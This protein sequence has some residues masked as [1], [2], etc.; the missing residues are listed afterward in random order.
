MLT[1]ID[2]FNHK[3]LTQNAEV[4]ISPPWFMPYLPQGKPLKILDLAAG[5]S[6]L[7]LY[8][9]HQ[10]HSLVFVDGSQEAMQKLSAY[11]HNHGLTTTTWVTDLE[12]PKTKLLDQAWFKKQAYEVILIINY[13]N[14][15][16]THKVHQL[17]KPKGVLILETFYGQPHLQGPKN[18]AFYLQN[19][20]L[21]NLHQSYRI[22]KQLYKAPK[23]CLA[24]T[25]R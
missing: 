18:P 10:G 21:E 1:K 4:A 7:G 17:L 15:P 20:H 23:I 13:L 5:L 9:A 25:P 16:L 12:D 11:G 2:Q 14:L 8:L 3:Y 19:K 6:P 22:L 24:L